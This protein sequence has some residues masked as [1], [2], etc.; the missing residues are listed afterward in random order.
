MSWKRDF[1]KEHG[2]KLLETYSYYSSDGC[3]LTKLEA[4]LHEN[5]VKFKEPDFLDIFNTV[6]A[7]ESDKYFSEFI[8]LC[9]TFIT[10][11]K[12][13]GYADIDLPKL[14]NKN[15]KYNKAFFIRRTDANCP[16]GNIVAMHQQVDKRAFS[17][18]AGTA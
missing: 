5:G 15:P 2:T 9:C 13:N 11:F 10:L 1:H 8:K 3:L 7:K 17:G 14:Q 4:L 6:Y 12:S 16:F 18:A